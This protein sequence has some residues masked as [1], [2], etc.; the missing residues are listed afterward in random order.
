MDDNPTSMTISLG[1]Q[2]ISRQT[3]SKRGAFCFPANAGLHIHPP[4]KRAT[5]TAGVG[6]P[7]IGCNVGD[8]LV[9]VAQ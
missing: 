7:Q 2:V 5:E 9:R 8:K 6:E 4:A 1:D 3:I